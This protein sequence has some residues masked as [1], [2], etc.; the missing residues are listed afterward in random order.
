MILLPEVGVGVFFIRVVHIRYR[1]LSVRF[2]SEPSYRQ[3]NDYTNFNC[4]RLLLL[5]LYSTPVCHV[6][7]SY[8]NL[9][10]QRQLI[11]RC[12]CLLQTVGISNHQTD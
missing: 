8:V 3:E 12:T 11:E 9:Q 5:L 4:L 2:V 6:S 7:L 10:A 1:H